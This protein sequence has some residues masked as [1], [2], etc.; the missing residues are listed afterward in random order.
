MHAEVCN[1]THWIEETGVSVDEEGRE[2]LSVVFHRL[3]HEDNTM[4]YCSI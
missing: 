2:I 3:L 4:T 1:L